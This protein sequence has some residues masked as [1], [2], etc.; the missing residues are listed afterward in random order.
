MQNTRKAVRDTSGAGTTATSKSNRSTGIRLSIGGKE[1]T[2]WAAGLGLD[3]HYV[4]FDIA[5]ENF[6][7]LF[8]KKIPQNVSLA[9]GLKVLI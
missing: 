8:S 7:M 4:C 9:A 1:G 5:T 3:F 6:G 2:R